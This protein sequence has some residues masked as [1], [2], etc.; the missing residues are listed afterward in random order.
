MNEDM[1]F[2]QINSIRENTLKEFNGLSEEQANQI[3]K[4][5]RNSILWNLGHIFTVQNLLLQN[6]GGVTMEMPPHN[7]E[8]FA[9]GTKPADWKGDAPAL[10]ELKQRL[11]EQPAKLKDLLTGK[12]NDQAAKPFR[13]YTTIGE[14]LIFT[15]YHEGLHTGAIK[16]LKNAG[17]V[18]PVPSH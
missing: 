4:G 17:N 10:E 9:P 1:L 7:I 6:Y 8:L 5:F 12:L 13:T 11:E 14:I 15:L 3:P 16:G 18:P 2:K